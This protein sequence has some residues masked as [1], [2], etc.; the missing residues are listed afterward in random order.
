MRYA[1]PEQ[2]TEAQKQLLAGSI[3]WH[4]PGRAEAIVPDAALR[5]FIAGYQALVEAARAALPNFEDYASFTHAEFCVHGIDDPADCPLND[6]TL[7]N[8]RRLIPGQ[9]EH[10]V[11]ETTEPAA[12]EGGSP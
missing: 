1:T 4:P 10:P 5:V 9:E 11:N 3:R 12:P 6:V 7:E 2:M 8:L